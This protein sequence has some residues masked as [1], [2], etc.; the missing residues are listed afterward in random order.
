VTIR[1]HT[2]HESLFIAFVDDGRGVDWQLEVETLGGTL[3]LES[4]TGRWTVLTIELPV[5]LVLGTVRTSASV[6][7]IA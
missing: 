7:A 3:H 5:A 6:R 4:E 2:D 1:A